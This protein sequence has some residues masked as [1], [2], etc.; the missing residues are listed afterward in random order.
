M[1]SRPGFRLL[2][3]SALVA[4]AAVTWARR[5]DG[6]RQKTPTVQMIRRLGVAVMY[7]D[8]QQRQQ[9]ST[10]IYGPQ[11]ASADGQL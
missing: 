6:T 4:T 3:L 9:I 7:D 2:L 10:H 8:Q 5:S 11:Q 1:L